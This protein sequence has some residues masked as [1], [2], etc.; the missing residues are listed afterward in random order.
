MP[1]A[2]S[3]G[4]SGLARR[5]LLI[6]TAS[7]LFSSSALL[8]TEAV[9][10]PPPAD[11]RNSHRLFQGRCVWKDQTLFA[12]AGGL[13]PAITQQGIERCVE[14][15]HS[16]LVPHADDVEDPVVEGELP[17]R[18]ARIREG[19]ARGH[20]EGVDSCLFEPLADPH[21]VLDRVSLPS[22]G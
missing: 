4:R 6:A 19:D 12:T 8:I 3:V 14:K 1:C 17:G 11:D 2:K 22:Q 15:E 10:K 13:L 7:H 16:E 5:G 18:H 9:W 20:V 21:R